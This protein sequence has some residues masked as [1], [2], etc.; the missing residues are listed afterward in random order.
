MVQDLKQYDSPFLLRL[1]EDSYVSKRDVVDSQ[2]ENK[3]QLYNKEQY[4]K[5]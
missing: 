2:M 5:D 3:W 4:S 1:V